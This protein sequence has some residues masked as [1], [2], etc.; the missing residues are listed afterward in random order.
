MNPV[1]F[2]LWG[3]WAF[4]IARDNT[5]LQASTQSVLGSNPATIVTTTKDVYTSRQKLQHN[6]VARCWVTQQIGLA[7]VCTRQQQLQYSAR[8]LEILE[9]N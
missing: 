2:V 9:L 7:R 6:R 1:I 8:P 3:Y 4:D 5:Q